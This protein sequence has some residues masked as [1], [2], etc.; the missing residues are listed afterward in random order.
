MNNSKKT[1]T[2]D[3]TVPDTVEQQSV[4]ITRKEILKEDHT[5]QDNQIRDGVTVPRSSEQGPETSSANGIGR[6]SNEVVTTKGGVITSELPSYKLSDKKV[7]I[8]GVEVSIEELKKLISENEDNESEEETDEEEDSKKPKRSKKEDIVREGDTK[9]KSVGKGVKMT[10][11]DKEIEKL[12]K[13]FEEFEKRESENIK[14]I[15]ELREENEKYKKKKN[16]KKE[17]I[18][19]LEEEERKRKEEEE[20]KRKEDNEK[21]KQLA[22][23]QE[24]QLELKQENYGKQIELGRFEKIPVRSMEMETSQ[25]N[26]VLETIKGANPEQGQFIGEQAF[27]FMNNALAVRGNEAMF[28]TLAN[29]M[30]QMNQ[31]NVQNTQQLTQQ[32]MQQSHDTTQAMQC[33][34]LQNQ[35]LGKELMD[36]K[37]TISQAK[38]YIDGQFSTVNNQLGTANDQLG[39]LKGAVRYAQEGISGLQT[40]VEKIQTGVGGIQSGI[41]GLQTGIGNLGIKMEEIEQ[42]SKM[43]IEDIKEIK[44]NYLSLI[45]EQKMMN[46][47]YNKILRFNQFNQKLILLQN[48]EHNMYLQYMSEIDIPM[49]KG[50]S[51]DA[52][53]QYRTSFLEQKLNSNIWEGKTFKEF[54]K[55]IYVFG[56][57]GFTSEEVLIRRFKDTLES[58]EKRGRNVFNENPNV[59]TNNI[60]TMINEYKNILDQ[61]GSIQKTNEYIRE[62]LKTHQ[63]PQIIPPTVPTSGPAEVQMSNTPIQM[64]ITNTDQFFTTLNSTINSAQSNPDLMREF[65]QNKKLQRQINN[66]FLNFKENISKK[67]N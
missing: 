9:I 19:K 18:K 30:G 54:V 47:Q 39:T 28:T 42:N 21:N 3:K 4:T 2:E 48:I 64:P 60:Q 50:A 58:I 29:A 31:L 23:V 24:K 32:M 5:L 61:L 63:Q 22:L 37:K 51:D 16:E 57:E 43:E 35:Y 40:D 17:I 14:I 44:A 25:F 45:D 56:N 7:T 20:R 66:T 65:K 26:N 11:K 55:D 49:Q 41:G 46:E 12:T 59:D 53:K 34:A 27:G 52:I 38:N 33:L 67:Q 15:K 62:Q 13:A 8:K 1:I 10:N 36:L 6:T